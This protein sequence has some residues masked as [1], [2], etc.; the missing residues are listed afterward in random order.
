MS[1]KIH[2]AN[3]ADVELV[4]A[5]M[6]DQCRPDYPDGVTDAVKEK[7][8]AFMLA[9]EACAVYRNGRPQ[10]ILAVKDNWTWFVAT[11][12]FFAGGVAALRFARRVMQKVTEKF[13]V[14][15]SFV[16][17]D[18]EVEKWMGFLGGVVCPQDLAVCDL[19]KTLFR[20]GGPPS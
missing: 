4:L 20:F 12:D 5:R 1:W 15:F 3:W 14:V 11:K 2:A 16:R 13:Q 19:G 8:A 9:G 17:D 10:F 18:P 7:M 6:A